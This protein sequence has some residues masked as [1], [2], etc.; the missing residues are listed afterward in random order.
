MNIQQEI[1]N[2]IN[3]L[4]IEKLEDLK[5]YKEKMINTSL[6][7]RSKKGVC[8]YPVQVEKSEFSSSSKLI[9]KISRLKYKEYSHVFQSGKSVNLFSNSNKQEKNDSIDGV[10]NNVKGDNMTISLSVAQMPEW[11][12]F[13][14]IGIQIL[15]D[16]NTYK[17]MNSALKYLQKYEDTR[18]RELYNI[19]YGNKSAS[20]KDIKFKL[21]YDLNASQNMAVKLSLQA[22]D[23][24]IIHGPPGTGKTTTLVNSICET[25]KNEN[26]VLV[27]TPS[28][29][30]LDLLVEKLSLKDKYIVRIGHPARVNEE[31]L[32]KTLDAQI[33]AHPNYKELKKIKK[34][35]EECFRKAARYK[36]NFQN[37]HRE[38]KKFMFQQAH[39]LKDE[40]DQLNYYIINNIL[41]K[42]EIIACTLVGAANHNIRGRKYETCF[43]DEAAQGL[44]AA[45]WIPI[46]KSNKVIFAGDHQQLPPTV[47]SFIAGKKGLTETLFEKAIKYE[48]PAIMLKEQYRMNEKIMQFSS[49]YFYD[50]KLIANKENCNH[51][52][53]DNDKALE[54]IDTAGCSFKEQQENQKTSIYNTEEAELLLKHI[55]KYLLE[56]D[57]NNN[58]DNNNNNSIGIIA[59]Y[60]AQTRVL[61]DILHNNIPSDIMQNISINTV[62]SFQGQ[63]RD[64]IYISLTRSN[65]NGEIGF[66][67]NT[68]RMNVAITRARKKLVIIGDSSCLGRNNFYSK[69]IDYT[70]SIGAYKSAFE[71]I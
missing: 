8:W 51:L 1:E 20:F 65:K 42:A 43:I 60:K 27:C 9:V 70:E 29:A 53:F 31:T 68:R 48:K 12:K 15:F 47:K 21:S 63:E 25:L 49:Q 19:L 36:R 50:N 56:I 13:G 4:N 14:N 22:K 67:N 71:L 61:S 11:I 46:I 23:V 6:A 40:A 62:D 44:E 41:S 39:K 26:Q 69:L 2:S 17:E 33:C 32:N 37:S 24:A 7:E 38:E 16:D 5:Q 52:V 3:L 45:C 28:N 55:T 10:I 66:L 34:M 58:L 18:A 57:K 64:I 54:F 59:P 35:A 30:S